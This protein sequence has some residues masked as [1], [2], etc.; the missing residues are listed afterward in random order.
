M[1][2][3]L[4]STKTE[5]PLEGNY[6]VS[7]YPPFSSWKKE[8]TRN[9]LDLLDR[10]DRSEVEI[11]LGLYVHI[12]F[13]TVRCLYCYYLSYAGKSDDLIESYLEALVTELSIYGEKT[14]LSGREVDFAYFGGGTPSIISA[15]QIDTLLAELGKILP[16][17]ALAEITFECAPTTIT[18]DKL[19]ALRDGG[20]TRIS[21]G[22]QQLDDDVLKKNGRV[23][24]V[25]DIEQ[26]YEMFQR[27]GFDMVNL[28]LIV[29]L[30]GQSDGSFMTGVDRI[31]DMAPES[32][33]IYQLEIPKNT[34][35]YHLYHN[36]KLDSEPASWRLK[37]ER[38][39][40][41]FEKLEEAGY[42]LRSAYTAVREAAFRPFVYQDAQ[43]RGGDLIGVGT[44]SFSYFA[45]AHY[46]NLTSVE[47][48]LESVQNGQ[49]PIER[50]YFLND[51][52]RL[53]REFILQ[54][55]L[56]RVD[57]TQFRSKFGIDIFERFAEP[58]AGFRRQGL[59]ERRDDQIELTRDGLLEVDHMLP[60]FYLD[61]HRGVRYS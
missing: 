46:Q 40:K 49:L 57:G 41:G 51:E 36:N 39:R 11:P 16:W 61:V 50:T 21:M 56:G 7:A 58:I 3:T 6:F 34:P 59:L 15:E 8:S 43:Y 19:R 52:E 60:A 14:A 26:A 30:V 12:P 35:L 27:V 55:K 25:R 18:E 48:Y 1:T 45:G 53:V 17:S 29:G 13:C 23:H 28:D 2:S 5:A 10:P 44:S 47:S 31:I 9:V 20:V 4:D 38:L 33:T 22:V 42:Q 32:V 54:L 37:R 24:L